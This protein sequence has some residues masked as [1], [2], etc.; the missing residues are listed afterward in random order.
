MS[1]I[2]G[3]NL[4]E[5]YRFIEWD[6]ETR[7]AT[8]YE[9]SGECNG[10]GACCTGSIF[11]LGDGDRPGWNA[12]NG[13]S[14]AMRSPQSVLKDK[15]IVNEVQVN[16]KSRYFT[17][18]TIKLDPAVR[19]PMLSAENRCRIHVGKGLISRAWP[20]SPKQV[21]PY[22]ECSYSFK[23]VKQWPF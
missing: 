16:G 8:E 19:C 13:Y 4:V 2:G 10:C 12:H 21:D 17:D 23:I 5:T 7:I 15:R 14:A 18:I 6:Y 9:R 3:T 11:Y 22:P 1:P 20:M